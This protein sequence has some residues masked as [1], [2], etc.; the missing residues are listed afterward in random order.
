MIFGADN[1][2]KN[3]RIASNIKSNPTAKTRT[4]NHYSAA[5]STRKTSENSTSARSQRTTVHQSSRASNDGRP[6]PVRGSYEGLDTGKSAYL[7]MDNR[8]YDS[9]RLQSARYASK[10][11]MINPQKGA[12]FLFT[13]KQ[14]KGII[15]N[16]T[17]QTMAGSSSD[18]LNKSL[19][20]NGM[21]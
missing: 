1:Q 21:F 20:I 7:Q 16:Y 10:D 12:S 9:K 18:R 5:I 3:L 6:D 11:K 13:N 2:N 15:N 4:A 19:R 17:N 14:N 8:G